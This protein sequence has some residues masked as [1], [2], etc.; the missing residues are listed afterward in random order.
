ME[1]LIEKNKKNLEKIFK[2]EG[3]V[4]AYLFGSAAREKMGPLSDID[5][6]VLFT[7]KVKKDAY[8]EKELHLGVEIEKLL[9]LERVDVVNLGSAESPLLKYNAVFGGKLIFCQDSK[10]KFE[11]EIKIMKE[12]EDTKYLRHTQYYFLHKRIKEG[13]FGK[14]P[15]LKYE[16]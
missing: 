4:L 6:A 14:L 3:V 16:F 7:E 13:K 11:T 12:Y 10:K 2:K 8:F 1:N 5:I 9:R 15:L